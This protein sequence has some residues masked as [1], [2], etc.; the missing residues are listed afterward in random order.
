MHREQ[1][2]NWAKAWDELGDS[3]EAIAAGKTTIETSDIVRIL[4]LID[5]LDPRERIQS[6]EIC[7]QCW[8]LRK[9]ELPV[10]THCWACGGHHA[11]AVSYRDKQAGAICRAEDV[12]EEVGF[13]PPTPAS[14]A[15]APV[16]E[17]HCCPQCGALPDQACDE[18]C[19]ERQC[20][21][22]WGPA[23]LSLLSWL[24]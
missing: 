12:D 6:A 19:G 18:T 20:P 10:E 9:E 24:E 5:D 22:L 11:D 2:S 23:Q 15:V 16:R 17:C 14:A 7:A 3:I 13:D 21:D 1:I 8:L 4:E